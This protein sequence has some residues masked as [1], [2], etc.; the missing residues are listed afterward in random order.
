M[1]APIKTCVAA[2]CVMLALLAMAC[3]G[4][5]TQLRSATEADLPATV[6]Q[7]ADVPAEYERF[8]GE[9]QGLGLQHDDK[10]LGSL[11]Q[12]GVEYQL[13]R[14]E[15]ALGDLT[16]I[17]GA[18]SLYGSSEEA[19]A[20]LRK[21][22]TVLRDAGYGAVEA[23]GFGAE[24]YAYSASFQGADYCAN[25]VG[26]SS[27]SYLVT[28][29]RSNVVGAVKLTYRQRESS[30]DEAGEYARKQIARVEAALKEQ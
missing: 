9:A 16:C 30:I 1:D 8:D 12:Y 4:G 5:S 27:A 3:G 23:P 15:A 7:A 17:E 6:L 13:P 26:E 28:F 25:Y 24:T 10:Q 20:G 11:A 2:L 22:D 21:F 14:D 19:R 18:T 29:V